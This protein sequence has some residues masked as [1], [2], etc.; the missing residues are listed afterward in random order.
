M[1]DNHVTPNTLQLVA[2]I[3][4]YYTQNDIINTPAGN[5]PYMSNS[6]IMFGYSSK[7]ILDILQKMK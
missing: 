2:V 7:L 4:G 6:G 1:A 5:I 3:S